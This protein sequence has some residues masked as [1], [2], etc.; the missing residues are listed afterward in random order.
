VNLKI[1]AA[2]LS[3]GELMRIRI[4]DAKQDEEFKEGMAWATEQL[5]DGLD[6]YELEESL[7]MQDRYAS[8]VEVPENV[9]EWLSGAR[10]GLLEWRS[11]N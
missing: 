4:A 1:K 9:R 7:E 8:E 6:H 10:A 11:I 5:D 2:I 3:I